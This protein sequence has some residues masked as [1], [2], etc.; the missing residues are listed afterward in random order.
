[1]IQA[2]LRDAFGHW[3][4]RQVCPHRAPQ[5]VR[6]P[7]WHSRPLLAYQLV[8][9]CLQA[10]NIPIG[11]RL[12]EHV[13]SVTVTVTQALKNVRDRRAH[14]AFPGSLALHPSRLE[15]Q[16]L[17]SEID[18][19]PAEWRDLVLPAR[20]QGQ[21]RLVRAAGLWQLVSCVPKMP[22]VFGAE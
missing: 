20:G 1:M 18:F 16:H 3:Q 9:P 19:I 8:E 12:S 2:Q 6:A 15:Q 13:G 22:K 11:K 5:V 14:R 7:W 4:G 21:Q 10:L 17:L